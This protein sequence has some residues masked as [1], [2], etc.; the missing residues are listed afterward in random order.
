MNA[1]STGSLEKSLAEKEVSSVDASIPMLAQSI[2]QMQMSYAKSESEA[3]SALLAGWSK[4]LQEQNERVKWE[5]SHKSYQYDPNS[6][7]EIVKREQSGTSN[8]LGL[9]GVGTVD[10]GSDA[11]MV[12]L[13][14][15]MPASV[16]V[17]ELNIRNMWLTGL[18]SVV[19]TTAAIGAG[20]TTITGASQ[21]DAVTG[22]ES[23]TIQKN[24]ETK[25]EPEK[26]Q[27][28]QVSVEA[29]MLAFLVA[30]GGVAVIAAPA[31]TGA[32]QLESKVIMG[33]WNALS[34]EA[35]SQSA[36]MLAG[37]FSAL[38]GVGMV[39]Q[40]AAE[41]L[42]KYQ[43]AKEGN[44]P[45]HNV[46]FA[47]NYAEKLAGS[48]NQPIFEAQILNLIPAGAEKTP[49]V[50]Q[51]DPHVLLTK[52]KLAQL[53]VAL[54][55]ILKLEEGV[56][57]DASFKAVVKGE[58]DLSK[59]DPYHTGS[60]KR[61]LRDEINKLIGDLEPKEREEVLYNLLAYMSEDHSVEKMLD[62][63]SLFYEVLRSRNPDEEALSTF[64]KLPL[65]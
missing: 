46:E 40:L 2:S 38:W 56:V 24:S 30:G 18:N 7:G 25:I 23:L 47:K 36:T 55:L 41:K 61:M 57:G 8:T 12:L 45:K 33:A 3:V 51:Q 52:A 29:T 62:Q 4:S 49:D 32:L 53:S 13:A 21:T 6:L 39:Y 16:G 31:A 28:K 35:A 19:A 1:F 50:K 9:Q 17:H 60:T 14:S 43:S 5:E 27:N 10:K 54:A 65:D 34:A 44:T 58:V 26:Q 64:G 42:E 59:N 48:L 37:W 11:D 22:A 20:A 63:Q 15:Q